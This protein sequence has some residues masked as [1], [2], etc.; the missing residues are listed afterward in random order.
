MRGSI[1]CF[2]VAASVSSTRSL[3]I[4]EGGLQPKTTSSAVQGVRRSI[5]ERIMPSRKSTACLGKSSDRN[6]TWPDVSTTSTRLPRSVASQSAGKEG[7]GRPFK[8]RNETSG[9]AGPFCADVALAV[10][11][12]PPPS[13]I[14]IC[15]WR[16]Y[17]L[18][19]ELTTPA[20]AAIHSENSALSSEIIAINPPPVSAGG[21]PLLRHPATTAHGKDPCPCPCPCPCPRPAR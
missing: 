11:V 6:S 21:G 18:I 17:R 19:M 14:K 8:R 16:T 3:G 13:L 20:T 10:N 4:V 5:C 15:R 12:L 1:S 2:D 7:V 9:K